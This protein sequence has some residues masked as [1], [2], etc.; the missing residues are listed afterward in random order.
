MYLRWIAI[1][2]ERLQGEEKRQLGEMNIER[3]KTLK[4]MEKVA[5]LDPQINSWLTKYNKTGR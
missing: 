3:F 4:L 1:D 2:N 5:E